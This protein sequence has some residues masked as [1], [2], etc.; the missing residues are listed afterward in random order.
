VGVFELTSLFAGRKK[1][2]SMEYPSDP[3]L[4][5]LFDAFHEKLKDLKM[6][7]V[8]HLASELNESEERIEEVAL[9]FEEQG[10]I[11]LIHRFRGSPI[12]KLKVF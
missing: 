3:T 11:E 8:M 9:I 10:W 1:V 2:K 12:I 6:T 5:T 7:T 4:H